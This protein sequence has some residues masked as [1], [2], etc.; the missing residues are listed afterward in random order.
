MSAIYFEMHDK[1]DV[2]MNGQRDGFTGKM[3][4]CR[5]LILIQFNLTE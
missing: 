2:V 3:S 5:K 4:I 1:I